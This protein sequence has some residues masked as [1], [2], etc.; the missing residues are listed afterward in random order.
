MIATGVVTTF[1]GNA[2]GSS[3]DNAIGTTA[4]FNAPSAVVNDG[5]N[6]YVSERNGNKIRKITIGGTQSVTTIAGT[7]AGGFADGP[8]VSATL[9]GI[10]GM[11][12]DGSNLYIADST[13][14]RIRKIVLATSIVSTLAGST[15]G[16]VEATGIAAQFAGPRGPVS[17]G[18]SL[19][20]AEIGNN[21]IKRI[22]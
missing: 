4:T 18:V 8:G 2:T 19:F 10:Y 16:D 17:D 5:T 11:T 20:I 9:S 21:K 7:G 14:H 13:N 1:A 15:T 12:T 3:V 22:Q 6:L